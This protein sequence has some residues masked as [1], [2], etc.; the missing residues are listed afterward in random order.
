MYATL[1]ARTHRPF[2]GSCVRSYYI[3]PK[4]AISIFQMNMIP[5]AV[6]KLLLDLRKV[7][8]NADYWY[9][10]A[11]SSRKIAGPGQ[12][13]VGSISSL[14]HPMSAIGGGFN[15]SVQR[16]SSNGGSGFFVK[17]SNRSPGVRRE[18]EAW[19]RKQAGGAAPIRTR[20]AC[21]ERAFQGL[22][23]RCIRERI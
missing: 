6:P 17:E 22:T 16:L 8:A 23:R 10:L 2:S 7:G 14:R 13:S 19:H 9:P 3:A 4:R 11:W 1:S 21:S 5:L 15:G 18:A 12:I 20:R